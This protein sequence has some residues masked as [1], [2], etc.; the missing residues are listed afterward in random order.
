[1]S[2]ASDIGIAAKRRVAAIVMTVATA[3]AIA[4]LAAVAGAAASPR[5]AAARGAGPRAVALT[6]ARDV[7]SACPIPFPLFPADNAWN[8]DISALPVDANSADYIAAMGA[9][10]EIHADFGTVWNGAPNGIPYVCVAGT[11]P[12]VPVDFVEFGG[13]SDPGPYPIPANA[14]VEGGSSSDGDRHVLVLDVDNQRLYE[15]YHAYPQGDGSW[16]AGS[17]AVFDL[18]S[19]ALRPDGWTSA[20]AAGLP[21]LP[22]LVRYDEV[23][24]EGE[25]DHALRF[26]VSETQMAYLYPATHFA[27]DSTDPDLPP[28]GLRLRLKAGIDISGLPAEIRTICRALKK[29]G[30]IVADNGGP[31]YI[32]G[33]PDARWDDDALHAISQLSGS[34]FEVVDTRSLEPGAV[35]VDI[36][37]DVTLREGDALTREGTFSGAASSGWTATVDYGDGSGSLPLALV[38]PVPAVP[39][40]TAGEP[41]TF[42]LSHR[43]ADNGRRVVTVTVEGDGGTLGTSRF[44]ATVRNVPPTVR[45]G[46]NVT[47]RAGATL[48]RLVRLSDPGADTWRARIAWGDGSGVRRLRL[49]RRTTFTIR[50]IFSR[51]GVYGVRVSVIDDDGGH[52]SRRFLVTVRRQ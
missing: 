7:G 41:G 31:W 29:Y 15:L 32:S 38:P 9:A 22:G 25:I 3:A 2:D 42:S 18:T 10:T 17:G 24:T 37:G 51:P 50:H 13:E 43:Y 33:A 52:G 36:G 48:R 14:P 45:A 4:L 20:D 26:T 1:M 35:M 16:H 46:R 49:G 44:S 5:P 8:A 30:M 27:S 34:D 23:V 47:L 19:N 12:K 11:Q 28:M 6:V 39:P 21:M 40:A